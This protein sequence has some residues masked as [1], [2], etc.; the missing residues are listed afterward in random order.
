MVDMQA[1]ITDFELRWWIS[2]AAN[3]G[4]G[5]VSAF[6]KACGKADEH[7]WTILRPTLIQI[8]EKYPKYFQDMEANHDAQ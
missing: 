6:A 5:F 2:R 8:S 7:N 1:T 3:Y 4:G